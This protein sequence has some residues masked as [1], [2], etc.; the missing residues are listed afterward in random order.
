MIV[1]TSKHRRHHMKQQL[2]TGKAKLHVIG[3]SDTGYKLAGVKNDR[4]TPVGNL[5]PKQS[6]AIEIGVK[7]YGQKAIK[8][9]K[10]SV[11]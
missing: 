3:N 10:M 7:K 5:I 1:V 2:K 4:L 6:T 11:I 8:V 9:A